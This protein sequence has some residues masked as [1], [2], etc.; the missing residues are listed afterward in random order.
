MAQPDRQGLQD[1]MVLPDRQDQQV[2]R[3][4]LLALEHQQQAQDQ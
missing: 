2:I 1:P 3:A 4:L